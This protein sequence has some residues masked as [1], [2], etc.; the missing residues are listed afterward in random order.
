MSTQNK[1]LRKIYK[2]NKYGI[3]YQVI[4]TP[5]D[6]DTTHV[7]AFVYRN[8][9]DVTKEYPYY[10]FSWVKRS[11]EG[12]EI[13]GNGYEMDIPNTMF[14][15]NGVVIGRFNLIDSN[16]IL[17]SDEGGLNT[18]SGLLTTGNENI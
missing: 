13:I 8:G 7:Q 16:G 12:E 9:V 18:V 6:L 15:F 10:L 4:S 5:K 2:S 17:A 3:N 1:Y 11:E 14:D